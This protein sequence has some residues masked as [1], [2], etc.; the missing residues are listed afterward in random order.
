MKTFFFTIVCVVLPVTVFGQIREMRRADNL[1]PNNRRLETQT[2]VIDNREKPPIS[3]YKIISIKNDTT[4]VDTTLTIQKDYRFNYLREDNFEL[5]PFSN[6]GRPYNRLAYSFDEVGLLPQFGA[7]ARHFNFMEV[8][9]IY[10]YHVPTPFTELFFKTVFEQGQVLDAFFTVN[11]SPQLNLSIGYKGLRS[12]GKYQHI[13]TSTG[14]FRI[15]ASYNTKNKRYFLKTHFVSQDLMNQE[16]GGLTPVAVQQ[17]KNKLDEF[18]DRSLLGV[19]FQ[20][21]ENVLLGKRFYLNH[22]FKLIKGKDSI[23]NNELSIGHILNFTDKEYHYEQATASPWLG[24]SYEDVNLND[25]LEFQE[26]TNLAY[27]EYFNKIVGKLKLKA[28]YADYKYGYSTLLVLDEETVPNQLSG[29]SVAVGASYI[30]KIGGFNI[31]ADAM[32]N[33]SGDF[34]GNYFTAKT[35]YEFDQNNRVEASLNIKSHAPNYNFL[36]YQSDYKSYNWYNNFENVQTQTFQLNFDSKKLFDLKA[37]YSQITNYAYFGLTNNENPNSEADTL[38]KPF[39]FSGTIKYVKLK[40]NKEFNY[41]VFALNNTLLYQNVLDGEAVFRAPTFVTRNTLYYKDYWFE[42]A[43]YLQ[44]G[45]TLNY[46]TSYKANGYDPVLAEFYVQDIQELNGFTR[47]DLFFNAKIS[48]ARIFF[49][50]ENFTTIFS[51]NTA[52]SAPSYP[53]RDFSIRF[54]LVWDFFL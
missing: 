37:S 6:V 9:D 5:L 24:E 32:I 46:F 13:L 41:G 54:G 14:N 27:L 35:G 52:F 31:Q 11:T 3:D 20:D 15:A 45:V 19:K 25:D 38:V 26:V 43:L 17:Y 36:L 40:A 47:L 1:D 2:T 39:Q 48:Q 18:D 29:N 53:Y 50:L 49:K 7:R 8:E 51:G 12:L 44:T 10:Y 30:K 42:K 4:F 22:Y 34:T 28:S 33:I 21:A 16:N 23:P